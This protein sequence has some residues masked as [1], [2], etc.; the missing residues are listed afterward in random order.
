MYSPG[1]G[2]SSHCSL[3]DPT[4]W[5][6]SMP[7]YH[8][9][10]CPAGVQWEAPR[11]R[12]ATPAP[13]HLPQAPHTT[14]PRSWGS[15]L[16][17]LPRAGAGPLTLREAGR[18]LLR[19]CTS[20]RVVHARR[21]DGE[22]LLMVGGSRAV[23]PPGGKDASRLIPAL[24]V[25]ECGGEVPQDGRAEPA[26]GTGRLHPGG[27]R[28]ALS[29]PQEPHPPLW[30]GALPPHEDGEWRGD[31]ADPDAAVWGVPHDGVSKARLGPYPKSSAGI[32][33]GAQEG[34]KPAQPGCPWPD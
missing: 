26:G 17:H 14:A 18:R 7:A 21:Q 31:R 4:A 13:E 29:G 15:A 16:P 5:G 3:T 2:S 28:H 22:G 30:R 24:A 25:A 1:R 33:S 34:W 8:L 20:W 32:P 6:I 9:P 27:E 12:A 10:P 19:R 23:G 11:V